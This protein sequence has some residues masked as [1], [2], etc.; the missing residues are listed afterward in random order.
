[1]DGWLTLDFTAF[2]TVFQ[3]YQDDG[4]LIMKGCVQ[5]NTIYSS[6]DFTSSRDRTRSA[7]SADQGLTNRVTGAHVALTLM[8]LSIMVCAWLGKSWSLTFYYVL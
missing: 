1:M 4:M 7:R 6:E 3:S 8:Q 5:W 2:S